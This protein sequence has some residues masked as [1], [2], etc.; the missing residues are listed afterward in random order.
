VTDRARETF[1]SADGASSRFV[2][3]NAEGG[4]LIVAQ[5]DHDLLKVWV[6]TRGDEP[7]VIAPEDALALGDWLAEA[8]TWL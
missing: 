8:R 4:E 1:R 7:A 2:I 3:H 6:S 5:R